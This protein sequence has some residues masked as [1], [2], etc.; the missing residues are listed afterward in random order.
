M[1]LQKKKKKVFMDLQMDYKTGFVDPVLNFFVFVCH[2]LTPW[3]RF[4]KYFKYFYKTY[5]EE[6]I[7]HLILLYIII[8]LHSYKLNSTFLENYMTQC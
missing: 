8:M 2:M 4:R 6:M 1:L 5:S 3:N 7:L